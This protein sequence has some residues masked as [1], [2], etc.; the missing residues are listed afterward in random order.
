MLNLL[1]QAMDPSEGGS[2]LERV[3]HI[4]DSDNDGLVTKDELE[5]ILQEIGVENADI[6]EFMWDLQGEEFINFS[7][8]V[9]AIEKF[10]SQGS[11]SLIQS[12]GVNSNRASPR[13]RAG[14]VLGVS[15]S[16]MLEK[17]Y[18]I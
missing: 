18:N 16:G 11:S 2:D 3:F 8:F 1:Q 4:C 10:R 5:L 13:S 9:D 15:I 17:D 7:Q 14:S 12:S 6:N